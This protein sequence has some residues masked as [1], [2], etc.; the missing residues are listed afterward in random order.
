M[1]LAVVQ[2]TAHGGLLHYAAQLA[3]ALAA[4][5]HDVELITA[6][7]NELEGRTGAARMR[8]VLA[9]PTAVASE[10]PGGWRRVARRAG[11]AVRLVRAWTRVGWELRRGRHDAALLTDDPAIPLVAAA[12]LVLTALPAAAEL[13]A[14]CHEPRP[15]NRWGGEDLY[16][17][18]R[19]L[20]A[21]LRHLYR[22][23]DLVLVHGE[24][25]RQ[26]LLHTWPFARA[27]IIPHGD[28]RI[29]A[30]S[31]PAAADE[32]RILFFGDWRRAKG[33]HVLMSAFERLEA[34]QP[35][36]RLTIAGTPLPDGDPDRVRR[37]AAARA[38]RV[39]LIDRYV[40]IDDL[41]ALFGRA[42]VVAAPYLAGSQSG[43]VH[44][45]MTMQ[46]AVVASDAGELGTTVLDGVTG[47]VVPAGD[48]GALAAA[49][50]EV[51][52]DGDFAA[53]LGA[54]GRRRLLAESG[55]ERVAERVEAEL[56]PMLRRSSAAPD[57]TGEARIRP[58]GDR[59]GGGGEQ[60]P[61]QR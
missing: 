30:P 34:P 2:T 4:R 38:D 9:A 21:L 3:D 11:I 47:R 17:S 39:E 10:A 50:A 35:A 43:V 1:R 20:P 22:R 12:Q 6:R 54:E 61:H 31:P 59:A 15:R 29:L 27:A 32:E 18:S 36:A 57:A 41:A 23:L 16:S 42:R 8:A 7:G 5:G 52:A 19:A 33:L 56:I 53:R 14:V 58:L 51:I 37:W 60:S 55:W 13:V 46:R 28:E 45:A 24:R 26:E 48:V 44:L 49:L 40:P 25:S